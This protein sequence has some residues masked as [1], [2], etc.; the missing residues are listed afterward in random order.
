VRPLIYEA[1]AA[2]GRS[3]APYGQYLLQ[4]V[5]DGKVAARMQV[6]LSAWRLT[7]E[8][9]QALAEQRETGFWKKWTT[10][11]GFGHGSDVMRVWCWAPGYLYSDHASA[12]GI[13]EVTGFKAKALTLPTA[14]ATPTELG[15]KHGLAQA[16]GTKTRIEPLFGVEAAPNEVWA[17][18]SDG[19]P[20]V[21]VRHTRAGYDVFVGVPQLTPELTHALAKLAGVHLFTKPGP[22]LW[23]ANGYLS[24]QA[25]TNGVV[26]I[27][28]GCGN[29]VFDALDGQKI[30]V[31]PNV[32]LSL[33]AG[34]VRVLRFGEK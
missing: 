24:M 14:A 6:F 16:W 27:D 2:L 20:A 18:Y 11:F 10:R 7:A 29:T 21:A 28:T 13:R 34:D 25:Q 22:A 5:I 32:E 9:R 30:G 4:D 31:G 12:T 33:E 23:A 1:R 26:R 19:S 17:T 3:G 8:Q 15:R